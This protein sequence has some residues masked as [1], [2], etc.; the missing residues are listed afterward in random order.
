MSSFGDWTIL[1]RNYLSRPMQFEDNILQYIIFKMRPITM[2]YNKPFFRF[3]KKNIGITTNQSPCI[4]SIDQV[5]YCR[6]ESSNLMAIA[7]IWIIEIMIEW[8]NKLGDLI[9]QLVRHCQYGGC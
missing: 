2:F 3:L 7:F 5:I 4:S 9:S 8:R 1:L 6:T